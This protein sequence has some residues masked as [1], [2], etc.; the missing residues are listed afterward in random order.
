MRCRK[1]DF[2]EEYFFKKK[3][4]KYLAVSCALPKFALELSIKAGGNRVNTAITIMVLYGINKDI[5]T[6]ALEY[7]VES[8]YLNGEEID[9]ADLVVSALEDDDEV[10]VELSNYH[11]WDDVAIATESMEYQW[12]C[13]DSEYKKIGFNTLTEDW[14]GDYSWN[15]VEEVSDEYIGL[16]EDIAADKYDAI[17][18]IIDN[19]MPDLFAVR[20]IVSRYNLFTELNDLLMA[21]SEPVMIAAYT[22]AINSL[23]YKGYG[24]EHYGW[25]DIVYNKKDE[26]LGMI[27]EHLAYDEDEHLVYLPE[28]QLSFHIHYNDV[29]DYVPVI[30][31]EWA[32]QYDNYM[33]Y[34]SEELQEKIMA[35]KNPSVQ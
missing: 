14:E 6:K 26:G 30:S 32:G 17:S 4:S 25:N 16:L 28:T 8:L 23:A 2:I 24:V 7:D 29:P 5:I 22:S 33:P 13:I 3:F 11:D 20:D 1:N 27:M 34:L 21:A 9:T 19:A 10:E 12:C 18:D 15:N 35:V 31:F